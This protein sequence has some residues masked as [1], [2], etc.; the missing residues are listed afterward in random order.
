MYI[1]TYWVG[2]RRVVEARETEEG[3]RAR[4]GV[5]RQRSDAG[6][7]ESLVPI[8][9]MRREVWERMGAWAKGVP[10]E[11]PTFCRHKVELRLCIPCIEETLA[12][13]QKG[14]TK[15]K[16]SLTWRGEGSRV[17]VQDR[18]VGKER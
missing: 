3:A 15:G 1:V 6:G 10:L 16:A 7:Q 8:R 5:L 11:K 13:E 14:G 9:V 12:M 18:G 17:G 4:A 2:E